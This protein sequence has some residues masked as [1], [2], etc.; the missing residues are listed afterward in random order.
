MPFTYVLYYDIQ[1]Y[2]QRHRLQSSGRTAHQHV[3]GYISTGCE[4]KSSRSGGGDVRQVLTYLRGLLFVLDMY[5]TCG[6]S[7][8]QS[9][10]LQ[11]SLG[12][13]AVQDST[14]KSAI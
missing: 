6:A 10:E 2:D 13:A 11:R 5:A 14:L 4:P 8:L 3:N 7:A 1:L 9:F 12:D